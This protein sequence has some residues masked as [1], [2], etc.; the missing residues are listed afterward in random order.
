[1]NDRK[2]NYSAYAPLIGTIS[3]ANGASIGRE[4]TVVRGNLS[5]YTRNK[6]FCVGENNTIRIIP[7]SKES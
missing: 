6:T 4:Y 5:D 7:F 1:M 2:I 3:S